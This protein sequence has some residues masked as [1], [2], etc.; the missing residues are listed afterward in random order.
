[1]G[2]R[3]VAVAALAWLLGVPSVGV[4]EPPGDVT[5]SDTYPIRIFYDSSMAD[6]VPQT[7]A[8][9]SL[10]LGLNL[11]ADGLREQSLKD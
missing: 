5:E 8:L 7:L 10:V 6:V 11:L 2:A 4:A 1:M 3:I 9:A